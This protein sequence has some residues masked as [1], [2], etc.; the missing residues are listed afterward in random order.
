MAMTQP[1]A[2][3]K[4]LIEFCKKLAAD[5]SA[6]STV[7][8]DLRKLLAAFEPKP[9]RYTM[10]EFQSLSAGAD[11]IMAPDP[12]YSY[13]QQILIPRNYY[14]ALRELTAVEDVP[15]QG[16]EWWLCMHSGRF[17]ATEQRDRKT[18]HVREVKP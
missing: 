10:P 5:Y 15:G 17:Y 9:K 8:D 12:F 16:R 11:Y 18:I 3:T 4:A 1:D 7:A 2:K 13:V 14:N 6:G